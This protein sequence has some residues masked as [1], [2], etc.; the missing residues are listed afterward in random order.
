MPVLMAKIEWAQL[1][2][3]AFL[4]SCDRLCMVGITNRFPV[5]SLPLAVNQ[6]MIAARVVDVR[7]GEEF[8][9]GL[10]VATPSGLWT[11][12]SDPDGYE[13]GIAGEYVLMTLKEPAPLPGGDLSLRVVT[14]GGWPVHAGD[15]SLR[16]V[17]GAPRGDPLARFATGWTMRFIR[18][19]ATGRRGS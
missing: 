16:G 15:S 1:C 3:L 4:D 6:F 12:P 18:A 14:R 11:G 7:P 5:P 19:Y 2:E 17:E 8:D 10:S 9:V 13:V